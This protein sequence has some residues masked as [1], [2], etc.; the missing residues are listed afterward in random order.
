MGWFGHA[1][2][3]KWRAYMHDVDGWKTW[4]DWSGVIDGRSRWVMI[5]RGV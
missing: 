4:F 3:L 5:R 1:E 2:T